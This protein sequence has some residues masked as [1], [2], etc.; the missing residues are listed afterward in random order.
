MDVF[1]K[2]VIIQMEI[3]DNIEELIAN[4]LHDIF[5]NDIIYVDCRK[6]WKQ[7]ETKE[8][9]WISFVE[10]DLYSKIKKLDKLFKDIL[11]D[12]VINTDDI[13]NTDKV[14]LRRKISNLEDYISS[15]DIRINDIC[16][17]CKKLFSIEC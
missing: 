5:L 13:I 9:R 14:F 10:N 8:N 15:E 7:Y 16:N 3:Y 2:S 11:I 4:I 1:C 6:E 12:Y 17:K